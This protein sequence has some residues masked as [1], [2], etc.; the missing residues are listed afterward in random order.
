MALN[1]DMDENKSTTRL[2]Q[3]LI[4]TKE[5]KKTNLGDILAA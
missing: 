3:Y 2:I 5:E 4:N 1:L